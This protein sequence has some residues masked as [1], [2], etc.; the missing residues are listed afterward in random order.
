MAENGK[1]RVLVVTGGHGF[2]REPFLALFKS[3]EDITFREVEHPKAHDL[4]KPDAAKQYDVLVLYD[5][6]GN[7]TD[8]AKANFVSL[9]KQGKG[10]VA[11]HH[12]LAGYP[13]WDEYARIIGGKFRLQKSVEGGVEKPASTF[14]HGVRFTVKI[15]D[16]NHPVTKGMKDFEIVDETYGNFD[17]S[18]NVKPLLT[19]DEPTSGKT[20]GWCHTYG[21]SRVVYIQLGHDHTAY[22]NPHYRRL[23]AQA[24]RY[25]SAK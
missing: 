8:E 1:I 15:A 24:I 19:T 11:L 22:E 14:K 18:P 12:A 23:V 13:A 5:M 9:L 3:I 20:I 10:V 17:V 6:W 4:F 16:P 21:K 7:I 2:E 25:A